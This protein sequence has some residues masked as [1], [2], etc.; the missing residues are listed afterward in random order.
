[1]KCSISIVDPAR[2]ALV[3]TGL[4]NAI[5]ALPFALRILVPGLREAV[6]NYARLASSLGITGWRLWRIVLLPVLRAPIGFA[7][8]LGTALSMGDLG[9]I[10][11]FA[12]A[13]RATLPLQIERLLGAYRTQEAAGAA[14][15]LTALSFA[16]F[17][18][19]DLWGRRHA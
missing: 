1:M 4:V 17:G 13:E 2:L 8:G 7:L 5:M 18:V 3:V 19:F 9:V 10:A 12:D 14:L 16:L 11:L 6:R 15:L